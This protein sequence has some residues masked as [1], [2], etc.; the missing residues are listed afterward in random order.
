MRAWDL[1]RP[2]VYCPAMNTFMWDHPLTRDHLA[3]MDRLGYIQVPPVEKLLACGDRGESL[4]NGMLVSYYCFVYLHFYLHS[5]FFL[6]R[7]LFITSERF[8][9]GRVM[10][11]RIFESFLHG[12]IC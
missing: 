12:L 4:Q 11:W 9:I 8:A 10:L 3:A 1:S 7:F 6:L 5:S 2:L